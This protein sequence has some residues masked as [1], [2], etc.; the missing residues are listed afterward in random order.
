LRVAEGE[1]PDKN[2]VIAVIARDRKSKGSSVFK[3]CIF[4]LQIRFVFAK[5][6]AVFKPGAAPED[7]Y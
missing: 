1:K 3:S 2:R 5:V 6:R 7:G 4:R